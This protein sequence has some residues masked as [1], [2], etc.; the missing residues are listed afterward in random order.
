MWSQARRGGVVAAVSCWSRTTA[1][2]AA[3]STPSAPGAA[4]CGATRSSA[5]SGCC[6]TSRRR[7]WRGWRASRTWP[8]RRGAVSRPGSWRIAQMRFS[9]PRTGRQYTA[10]LRRDNLGGTW[11]TLTTT[12][13]WW[14]ARL[15]R[16]GR[17][18]DE[19]GARGRVASGAAAR[20]G[21]AALSDR[22]DS[23]GEA[24]AS[25]H[26][27]SRRRGRHDRRAGDHR[28]LGRDV[29]RADA[30]GAQPFALRAAR[31]RLRCARAA[32]A[33]RSGSIGWR[34]TRSRSNS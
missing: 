14:C 17:A 13:G 3:P 4:S 28:A 34:S 22:G 24:G 2:A 8:C 29:S 6:S 26:L 12:G 21:N 10:D 15:R 9:D 16:R 7:V 31:L 18:R 32:A 23:R 33:T 25:R 11:R 1:G 20:D 5:T 30:D 19:R 27:L